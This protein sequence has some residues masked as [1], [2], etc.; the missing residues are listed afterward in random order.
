MNKILLSENSNELIKKLYCHIR[1]LQLKE[2]QDINSLKK[3][4][5]KNLNENIKIKDV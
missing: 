5:K 1:N 4:E 3:D 2:N